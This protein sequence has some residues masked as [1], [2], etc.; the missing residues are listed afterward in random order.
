[1][2]RYVLW[3]LLW[4]VLLTGGIGCAP[5]QAGPPTLSEHGYAVSLR[6][7][8]DPI[9]LSQSP[10]LPQGASRFGELV[11]SVRDAQGRPV[12]GVPVEFELGRSWAQSASVTPQRAV[13]HNGSVRAIVEPRTIG[14][15]PV[16]V[17]VDNVTRKASFVAQSPPSPG[18]MSNGM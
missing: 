8:S 16:I 2:V 15:I 7:S 10:N 11:V 6:A 9:V 14:V 1:M 13:T 18:G 4:L 3:L 5:K 17:R 12:D